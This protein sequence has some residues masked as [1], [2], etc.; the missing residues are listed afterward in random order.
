MKKEKLQNTMAAL[1]LIMLLGEN[2][3]CPIARVG[4]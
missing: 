1:N 3:I 2:H 4:G